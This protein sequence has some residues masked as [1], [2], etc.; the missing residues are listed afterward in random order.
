MCFLEL[1][2]GLLYNLR[3]NIDLHQ[4]RKHV[5]CVLKIDFRSAAMRNFTLKYFV[6]AS[7]SLLK[8]LRV[9][10]SQS[11]ESCF[12]ESLLLSLSKLT[13]RQFFDK[14]KNLRKLDELIEANVRLGFIFGLEFFD[15]ESLK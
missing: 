12:P 13:F 8:Q 6:N 7:V 11:C 14:L 1:F 15:K 5:D 9:F 10:W 2:E 4:D 3:L